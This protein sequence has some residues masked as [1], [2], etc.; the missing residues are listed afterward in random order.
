MSCFYPLW[1]EVLGEKFKVGCG[2]C[3]GCRLDRARDWAFRC[4]CEADMHDENSF[5][6]LTY[7]DENL[8][9]NRSVKKQELS[10]FIRRLRKAVWPKFIRFYGCGEYGA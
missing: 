7:N 5:V 1:R 10:K 3:R 2:V 4:M 8:P 6:T 9:E